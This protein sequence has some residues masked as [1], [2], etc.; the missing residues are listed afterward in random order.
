MFEI[1]YIL[2]EI[3]RNFRFVSVDNGFTI[4]NPGFTLR[5][6]GLRVRFE[7]LKK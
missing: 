6:H 7:E 3:V 1:K 2:T 5:P 4:E